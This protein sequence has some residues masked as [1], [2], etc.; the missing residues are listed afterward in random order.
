VTSEEADGRPLGLNAA[1]GVPRIDWLGALM[2]GYGNRPY[3]AQTGYV[4]LL[5]RV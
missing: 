2:T 5:Y 4:R 1:T 3:R